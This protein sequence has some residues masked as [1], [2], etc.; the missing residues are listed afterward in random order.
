ML[1]AQVKAVVNDMSGI[2][3]GTKIYNDG[4]EIVEKGTLILPYNLLAEGE[5]LTLDT[6]NVA[7][8]IG[9]INYE[10]NEKENYITYLGTI[11]N[12]KRAQFDAPLTAASYVIYKDKA[13]NKY[14]VYSQYPNGSKSVNDLL[15]K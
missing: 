9:K 11:V 13:G 3:F 5:A 8:S 10:V 2:R 15:N 14:T 4:D 6:P 1:G 12:I 7:R